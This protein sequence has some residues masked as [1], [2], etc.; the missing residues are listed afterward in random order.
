VGHPG[1]PDAHRALT[2]GRHRVEDLDTR[3]NGRRHGSFD[4]LA[5]QLIYSNEATNA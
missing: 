5:T 4:R 1:L 3:S 2:I